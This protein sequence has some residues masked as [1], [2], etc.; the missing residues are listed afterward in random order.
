M[1][2]SN[3]SSYLLGFFPLCPIVKSPLVKPKTARKKTC[4][5]QDLLIWIQQ[6][7]EKVTKCKSQLQDA[8]RQGK[9]FSVAKEHGN[10][11]HDE[12]TKQR[13]EKN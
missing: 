8:V 4:P 3:K 13:K 12:D 2:E 11:S 1:S 9:C 5:A 6:R 7:P 10:L